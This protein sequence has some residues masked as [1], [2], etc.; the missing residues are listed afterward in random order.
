MVAAKNMRKQGF[1]FGGPYAKFYKK[2]IIDDNTL[3]FRDNLTI[4]EDCIF[5]FMYL[6]YVNTIAYTNE[7]GYY[8]WQND[9]SAIHKFKRGKGKQ[10]LDTVEYA[11]S[12]L[13]ENYLLEYAQ[14]G[15][16]YYLNALKIDWCHSKNT[17][18]YFDRKR[19]ALMWRNKPFVRE[20]FRNF[21]LSQIRRAAIPIALCAKMK[22]F[23]LCDLLLKTKEKLNIR[24]KYE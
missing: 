17:D 6:G 4:G 11:S 13:R 12:I 2:E 7:C 22:W 19:E 1:N 10:F 23:V 20:A 8:Y 24:F 9:D 18:S 21:R 16:R 15:V 3:F 5:N 14:F